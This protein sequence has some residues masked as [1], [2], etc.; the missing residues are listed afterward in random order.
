MRNHVADSQQRDPETTTQPPG[1]G[2]TARRAFLP[3]L[4]LGGSESTIARLQRPG[5]MDTNMHRASRDLAQQSA[6]GSTASGWV[7]SGV[8]AKSALTSWPSHGRRDDE[9]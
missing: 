8:A 3:H 1:P 7:A 9:S 5:R 6:N 2:V 4:A